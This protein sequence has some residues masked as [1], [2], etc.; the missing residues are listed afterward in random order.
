MSDKEKPNLGITNDDVLEFFWLANTNGWASRKPAVE[1]DFFNPNKKRIK[2]QKENFLYLDEYWITPA[3]NKSAGTTAILY[4]YNGMWT[5]VWWMSYGGEYQKEVIPFLKKAIRHNIKLRKFEGGRGPKTL[6]VSNENLAYLNF[7]GGD[8]S[9]FSGN[10][11][12]RIFQ[13]NITKAKLGYHYYQGM[14]LL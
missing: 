7:S 1:I 3:N 14:S 2:F 6:E 10:E 11:Y 13:N 9:S 4:Q 12:I 5:P 8:F